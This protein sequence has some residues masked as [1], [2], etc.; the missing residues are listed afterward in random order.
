[1][2]DICN[3][4][5]KSGLLITDCCI[6][7]KCIVMA[8]RLGVM[9]GLSYGW[10]VSTFARLFAVVF[11]A[12]WLVRSPEEPIYK[13]PIPFAMVLFLL[14]TVSCQKRCFLTNLRYCMQI[15]YNLPFPVPAAGS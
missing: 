11:K 1:M 2:N 6:F 15:C 4:Y 12:F 10:V 5:T 7:I 8:G 14:P 9:L 13:L 3:T